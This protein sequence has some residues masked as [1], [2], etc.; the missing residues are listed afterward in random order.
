VVLGAG[1]KEE[2]GRFRSGALLLAALFVVG[3]VPTMTISATTA[4]GPILAEIAV[5]SFQP[6]QEAAGGAESLR[7]YQLTKDPAISA[8][9]AGAALQNLAFVGGRAASGV[10]ERRPTTA[11][12]QA[13][14]PD[15]DY[16]PDP[17]S[18]SVA[19]DL[20]SRP[21]SSFTAEEQAALRQAATHPAQ[22]EFELL[23]RAEFVDVVGGRWALP[24]PDSTTFQDLWPPFSELRTAGLARVALAAVEV[25]DGQTA[26]AEA[27][28]RELI[29]TGFLLIDQG[30]TLLDNLMGVVLANMGG[31]A[32]EAYYLRVGQT[33]LA[34]E[35]AWARASAL[36][37]AQ[38][39]RAGLIPEDIHSLLQGI[40]DLVETE[41]ALRGLRW[42]YFATFNTL[43]PCINLHKM[44]FGPDQTYD[45]WRERVRDAL[46]RVS[47]ERDLFELA[48]S[49]V[50]GA[51]AQ[52]EGFFPRFLS[53]TLG[54]GGA[55]GSCASLIASLQ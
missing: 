29:S 41:G 4:I 40:P 20:L 50:V 55:P 6:V 11:Y 1:P 54:S 28:L 51:G 7:R 3:F 48:E 5:P 42:E 38:K 23:A 46:V 34:E 39:A 9:A 2:G 19:G 16:F 49:G 26:E 52:L 21:V 24:F 8:E 13:W 32:L 44:V 35:L 45:D 37:S 36:S 15:A 10:V 33:T 14:F 22:A 53:L 47:G 31:D 30:P 27:T 25:S 17:F 18:E 12:Q 43:A